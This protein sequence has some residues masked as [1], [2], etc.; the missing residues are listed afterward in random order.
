MEIRVV[1]FLLKYR[2]WLSVA[3][4][5]VVAIMGWGGQHLYFDSDYKSFFDANNPQLVAFEKIQDEYTPSDSLVILIKANDGDLFTE[6]NLNIILAVTEQMWQTPFGTRVDSLSNYQ[7]SWAEGDELTVE[8]LVSTY[9]PLTEDRIARIK[10]IAMQEKELLNRAISLDGRTTAISVSVSI[11]EIDREAPEDEQAT[12]RMAREESFKAIARYGNDVVN[13]LHRDHPELSAHTLGVPV[14]NYSINGS[15][16]DDALTLLP[17]MYGIILLALAV[18]FRSIGSVLGCLLIIGFATL[19]SMG[20]A[21]WAGYTLNSLT[22]ISPIIILTIAVC[23]CVHLIVVYLRYLALN[24]EPLAA[25]RESLVANLQP[26]VLTSVTT[27]VGFLTLNFSDS[28]YFRNFGN[29]S[30]FG[31][32][33]AMTLTLTLMPTL[34]LW[35]VRQ[36]RMSS[37]RHQFL[38]SIPNYIIKHAKPVFIGTFLVAAGLMALVPLNHINNDPIDFF[39]KGVPYRDAADF[40]AENLPGVK[41][42]EY[43]LDCGQP[44]CINNVAYLE[45]LEAFTNWLEQQHGVVHVSS[46]IDVVKRL[47]RNMHGEQQEW[48]RIPESRE[49]AAQYQLLYE[50]S[51]PYGL[52]L[53]NLVN[54][55]KSATR[56]NVSL[57]KIK[58]IELVES[59][60]NAEA[61]LAQNMP[62]LRTPGASVDLMFAVQNIK[63]I[64]SMSIGAIFAIIGVTLTIM[65][66]TRSIKHS[67]ISAIP[68]AFP[69]AMGIGIWGVIVGEVNMAVCIVFSITLGLVVDNTVHFISKYRRALEQ[70]K[71][72]EDAIRYSFSTV[73]PALVITAAV[74][75]MGFGILTLS[76]FNINA[77]MGGLTAMTI[78]IALVFDL[79]MLPAVLLLLDKKA[80]R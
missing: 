69:A 63:D 34:A 71:G 26:I 54:L 12:Q 56:I 28:P 70:G 45:Q 43:S 50:L 75:S 41:L 64:S 72:I 23:D 6:K 48:Y 66:A 46:Y 49:L 38:E 9:E 52:D 15:S 61:W 27:T 40:A 37:N 16:S 11:P 24:N 2:Y 17:A 77:H 59:E 36:S 78:I 55:D 22:V 73:G 3:S 25:M 31:V 19:G 33:F 58:T 1:N 79:L 42:L 7:H 53:N 60:Q 57:R 20:W 18:F 67:L 14:L 51:L 8:D 10:A 21:G 80:I 76:S 47:N 13:Q 44:S 30:G 32:M 74:L 29:L 5:V 68:N 4:L 62:D 65:L 35:F 39:K